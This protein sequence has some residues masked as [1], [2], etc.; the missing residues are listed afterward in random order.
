MS[1]TPPPTILASGK[2]STR[3]STGSLINGSTGK[4]ALSSAADR[5]LNHHLSVQ[6][7]RSDALRSTSGE[8]KSSQ[9]S[10]LASVAE[11]AAMPALSLPEAPVNNVDASSAPEKVAD[12]SLDALEDV[13]EGEN[14]IRSR[15]PSIVPQ[16]PLGDVTALRRE[17]DDLAAK[18]RIIEKKRI[19]D[20]ENLKALEKVQAD[21]DRFE[22]I[23]Q[24]LHA[25]YQP[26]QQELAKLRKQLK[27]AEIRAE[28]LEA[29][30]AENE[31]LNEMA[32]LDKEMAEEMAETARVELQ[33][34]RQKQEELELEVEV[35]REENQE[36]GQEMSPEERTSQGWLQ[37]ERSNERYR[38][39]LL[40]LRDVTQQQESDLRSQ[41]DDLEADL[42]GLS[43]VKDDAASMKERLLQS[44]ANVEDLRQQLDNALGAEDMIE[45]LTSKNL[46]LND[47]MDQLR[48]TV[49]E[50]ESLKE[51][52]DELEINHMETEK[53]LQEEIDYQEEVLAEEARKYAVQE[54]NIQD[55]EYTV[56]RF[57][58]LV[59]SLQ[60][61]LE[62]IKASQQLTEAQA[63]DLSIRSRA[64]EDL[65]LKLQGSAAKAQIKAIEIEL[66]KLKVQESAEHLGIIELFL[67]E[68]F[69]TERDSIHALL[70]YRRLEYKTHMFR[71]FLRE[72]L[73]DGHTMSHGKSEY[74]CYTLMDKLAWFTSTSRRFVKTLETCDLETFRRVGAASFDLIPVERAIDRWITAFENNELDTAQC[75]ADLS[76]YDKDCVCDQLNTNQKQLCCNGTAFGGYPYL[77]GP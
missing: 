68:S 60:S 40:R 47:K 44:E 13:N 2:R 38:E 29:A 9:R 33:T 12:R 35:L 62:D 63:N 31:T 30:Q 76:R 61:D 71:N 26:Q 48:T 51:L 46:A 67:P 65:N 45:D 19:D 54:G 23:I 57:R 1:M 70:R 52:S 4:L 14:T 3:P 74:D 37:L 64:I 72:R 66:D 8:S 39:A 22:S 20:R 11:T 25:K 73:G 15:S 36:L 5:R 77:R 27:D 56:S 17:N 43:K 75:L 16:G 21:R 53:Q 10:D 69:Q 24:K 18:L 32:T 49:E 6:S 41:I 55:L 59:I 34:L 28:A 58:D 50:L 7:D 42:R